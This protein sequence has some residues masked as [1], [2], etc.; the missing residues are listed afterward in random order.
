MVKPLRKPWH[1]MDDAEF[2]RF[3]KQVE[4]LEALG[5]EKIA[6]ARKQLLL[7]RLHE[8]AERE[9]GVRH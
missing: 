8:I 5:S 7:S 3:I 4:K 9:L 6:R 2:D 1:H